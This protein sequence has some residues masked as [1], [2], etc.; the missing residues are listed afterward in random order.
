V[1]RIESNRIVVIF[2]ESE[3]TRLETAQLQG[4]FKT[5]KVQNLKDVDIRDAW[6]LL[7]DPADA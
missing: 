6:N 7:I 2:G 1:N 3:R 4:C 5:L